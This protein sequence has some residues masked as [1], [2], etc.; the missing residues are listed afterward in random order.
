MANTLYNMGI[1]Y[2]SFLL[3]KTNFWE[4]EAESLIRKNFNYQK[5]DFRI[6]LT[7]FNFLI[8]GL[9]RDRD[10]RVKIESCKFPPRNFFWI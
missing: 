1:C 3:A 2:I 10:I 9:N 6:F 5:S 8:V 4:I 7:T